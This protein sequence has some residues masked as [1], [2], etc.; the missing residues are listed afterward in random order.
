MIISDLDLIGIAGFPSKADPPLIIDPDAPL[1]GAVPGKPKPEV[2]NILRNDAT[3]HRF[4]SIKPFYPRNT[5]KDTKGMRARGQ[6]ICNKKFLITLFFHF[7]EV[8]FIISS[9]LTLK[10]R[11][12]AGSAAWREF[13]SLR[14]PAYRRLTLM[15]HAI[16]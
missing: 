10:G 7:K 13:S 16:S 12:W 2:N 4:R 6:G 11:F 1:A 14:S 9:S 5:R 8:N 15:C 3:T